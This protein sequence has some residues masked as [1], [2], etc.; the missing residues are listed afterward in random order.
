[1]KTL[2]IAA[3]F[4]AALA[5]PAAAQSAA[6]AFAIEHFNMSLDSAGERRLVPTGENTERVS[7][8]GN[9]AL[10]TALDVFNSSRDSAGE[11]RGQTGSA[12]FVS[13]TPAHA[14]GIFAD[15]EA[16]RAEDQ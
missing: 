2:A 13:N 12:T 1:M 10:A 3:A 4:A 6:T 11:R 9:S 5:A 7:I 8:R 15:I 14:A 16:A